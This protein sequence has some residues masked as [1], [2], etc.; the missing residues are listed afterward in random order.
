VGQVKDLASLKRSASQ[1]GR[2]EI[3]TEHPIVPDAMH[4]LIAKRNSG[5]LLFH[6][7]VVK[8]QQNQDKATVGIEYQSAGNVEA[9]MRDIVAF[10]KV[11]WKIEDVLVVR[12]LGALK[13]GDI[14]SLI[15]VSAPSSD[16]AF[17]CCKYGIFCLKKMATIR[18]NE[19]YG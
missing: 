4:S 9:E 16:D 8:E 2:M 19:L 15:A 3:V 12:R 13:I 10:L 14:I 17:D 7:A 6:Y 1:E 5:S 11:K 18:K